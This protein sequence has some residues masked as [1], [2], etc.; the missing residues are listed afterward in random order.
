MS[1]YK[2]AEKDQ[3]TRF[4]AQV[5]F[6]NDKEITALLTEWVRRYRQLQIPADEEHGAVDTNENDRATGAI[7][8]NIVIMLNNVDGFTDI[9]ECRKSLEDAFADG[10][11]NDP[12]ARDLLVHVQELLT[13]HN[14]SQRIAEVQ[15]EEVAEL[16]AL[17]KPW[18]K[19]PES[20]DNKDDADQEYITTS[21]WPL[22]KLVT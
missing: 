3:T 12:I 11:T 22:V 19:S 10:Y 6:L 17:L 5:E 21:P 4:Q 2:K 1:L 14:V 9:A 20:S 8:E 18:I 16:H 15:V 13:A 7:L